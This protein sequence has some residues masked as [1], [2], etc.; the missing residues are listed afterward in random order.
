MTESIASDIA[1]FS[2]LHDIGK[3]AIPDGILNKPGKLTQEEFKMMKDHTRIGGDLISTIL[4]KTASK[5]LLLAFELTMYHHEKWDGSGY[6]VGL[7]GNDIPISARI[8]ALADVYD[9]LTS[10]RV[11]KKAL[12]REEARSIIT[13]SA[14]SHFDPVLVGT[15]ER[16]EDKFHQLREELHD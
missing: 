3:V 11:Y 6:P 4:R 7:T 10:D 2:P 9:A 15:F 12:S 13:S 16:L 5:S 8:M 1:R 14:G